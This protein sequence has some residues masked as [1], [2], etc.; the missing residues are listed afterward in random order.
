VKSSNTSKAL[1]AQPVRI[2]ARSAL[3]KKARVKS[4]RGNIL[5]RTCVHKVENTGLPCRNR[6]VEPRTR[7]AA[8]VLAAAAACVAAV[9]LVAHAQPDVLTVRA[10][11]L[12]ALPSHL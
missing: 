7:H 6:M 12:P 1:H 3:Q 8:V 9:S 10:L 2:P 11:R 4:F 5:A